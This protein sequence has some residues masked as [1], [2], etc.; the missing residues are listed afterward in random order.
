M[1]EASDGQQAFTH[2]PA[3]TT[4]TAKC[5][6]E[7]HICNVQSNRFMKPFSK[8]CNEFLNKFLYQQ[9]KC[10]VWRTHINIVIGKLCLFS[11]NYGV[12][13]FLALLK[14]SLLN[15]ADVR[16][17]LQDQKYA[18]MTSLAYN[19]KLCGHNLHI[20]FLHIFYFLLIIFIMITKIFMYV[21]TNYLLIWYLVNCLIYCDF[22][23]S[24]YVFNKLLNNVMLF[25][26]NFPT[27]KQTVLI[28]WW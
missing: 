21:C 15:C 4:H 3:P 20:Y 7:I 13:T 16:L 8:F 12:K 5:I 17:H 14:R 11:W 1:T 22:T 18:C 26:C 2:R 28:N 24:E 23:K 19:Q 25:R 6:K 9:S 10:L 27:F